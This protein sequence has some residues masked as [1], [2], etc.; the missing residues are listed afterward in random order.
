MDH[1]IKNYRIKEASN[2]NLVV[3][4]LRTSKDI[5]F[6]IAYFIYSIV[7]FFVSFFLIAHLVQRIINFNTVIG[8]L[9]SVALFLAG[10]YYFFISFKTITKAT[11]SVF[12]IDKEQETFDARP[13][14]YKKIRF[15]FNEIKGFYTDRKTIPFESYYKGVTYK[16]KAN[17]IG[18]FVSLLNGEAIKIHQFE[19]TNLWISNNENGKNKEVRDKSRQVTILLAEACGKMYSQKFKDTHD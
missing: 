5:Y 8:Y 15:H 6:S 11:K 12:M 4:Y 17:V 10:Q 19:T 18:L 13:T 9:V 2:G 1:L 16:K 3:D 14:R 7:L